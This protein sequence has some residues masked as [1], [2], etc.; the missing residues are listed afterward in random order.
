MSTPADTGIASLPLDQIEI[1]PENVRTHYD[2]A[3]LEGFRELVRTGGEFINAP[4]VYR[5][6]ANRYRV[7]HGNTRVLA[8]Q[9]ILTELP[10][11]VVPPPSSSEERVVSQLSENLAQG[12][13]SPLDTARA[14]RQLRKSGL[15]IRGIQDH[16]ASY[17]VKRSVAWVH[18][19]LKMLELPIEVQDQIERGEVKPWEAL[20]PATSKV[21]RVPLEA[22]QAD[23]RQHIEDLAVQ[24][25][26]EPPSRRAPT[27]SGSGE[28]SGTATKRWEVLPMDSDP[29][30]LVQLVN[31]EGRQDIILALNTLKLVLDNGLPPSD[32]ASAR[33]LKMR[34]RRIR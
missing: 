31:E 28:R 20:A 24:L 7:K 6:G 23:F 17:G 2:E 13:L 30:E 34:F 16:L 15:S 4:H 9:G 33:L 11:R 10:V 32:S 5:V 21:V 19:T 14:L 8:A 22:A 1:D 26:N 29:A 3:V 27:R 12:G 25:L 18:T